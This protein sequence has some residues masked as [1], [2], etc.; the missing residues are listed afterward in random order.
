MSRTFQ[1]NTSLA[2][3]QL[4]SSELAKPYSKRP[5]D[6]ASQHFF[7]LFQDDADHGRQRGAHFARRNPRDSSTV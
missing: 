6:S 5:F 4:W 3:K 7:R 2:W 1:D